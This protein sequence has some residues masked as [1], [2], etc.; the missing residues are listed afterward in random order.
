[1][2]L[3]RRRSLQLAVLPTLTVFG[4]ALSVIVGGPPSRAVQAPEISLDMDPT[5]NTYDENTNSMAV[6]AIEN[7]LA[8]DAANSATH[9]HPTHLIIENVEDLIAFQVRL[10]YIGDQLRPNVWNPTPFTDNLTAQSVGFV[11]LPLDSTSAT[12]RS[13]TPAAAIPVA[14]PDGSNT[15]QTALVGASYVGTQ[16]FPISPDTPAKS[17]PDDTSYSAP[18]G[19]VLGTLVLQVLGDESG[20]ASLFIDLDDGNPNSPGTRAVVFTGTGVGTADIDLAESALFD[21][22]HAEGAGTCQ[23]VDVRNEEFLN[24]TNQT[25]NGLHVR[26]SGPI[27]SPRL[28]SNPPGCFD[29][30][31][32]GDEASGILDVTWIQNCVDHGESLVIEITSFGVQRICSEFTLN[33]NVLG[34]A[35]GDSVCTQPTASPS[36]STPTPT[37]APTP[38]S[39]S[40]P[41]PTQTPSATPDGLFHDGAIKRLRGPTSVRLSSGVADNGT[42]TII[43]GNSRSEHA[44]TVGIYLALLPPGGTSNFGGCSP[45]GVQNLGTITLLPG[46][47]ITLKTQPNWQCANPAAVDGMAWSLKAIAD[48]HG[49]DFG[50][51]STL[52]QMFDGSCNAALASDDSDDFNSTYTRPAPRVVATRP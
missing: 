9:T 15:A 46:D 51:C 52:S 35:S 45:A 19:G 10:N 20:Q 32:G 27:D 26:F 29:P 33:G 18:T 47:Y 13:V 34:P 40:S 7:C 1:M 49:D 42:V 50:P 28:T 23:I 25:A 17:S 24:L 31:F 6:G 37:R 30:I 39:T 43:A 4:V 36:P 14:P 38:T 48:V 44:D 21:G 41:A 3:A 16:D 8:T 22:F 5:G 2:K 12:H 11:N